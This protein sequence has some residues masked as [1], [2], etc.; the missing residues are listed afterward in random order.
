MEELNQ[1]RQSEN[2]CGLAE[3]ARDRL[4]FEP[5]APILLRALAQ[6]LERLQRK[7]AE[8]ERALERL[9]ELKDR[10]VETAQRLSQYFMEMGNEK[11]AVRHLEIALEAATAERQYDKIEELWLDMV[12]L[13][14]Q[15]LNFF[16]RVADH[17]NGIKQRQ[18]ASVLLQ[19][20]LPSTEERKDWPNRFRLLRRI[21]EY[22]P[23]DPSLREPLVE[24]LRQLH[25]E[26]SSMERVL[27]Y[28]GIRGNRPLPEALVEVE[29]FMN[30]LPGCYVRH[31]DWGIGLVKDLNMLDRRVVINF[32][33][34]RDHAMDVE[35]AQTVIEPLSA[36][37]FRV[38]RVINPSGLTAL[39]RENP[40]GLIKLLLKSYGGSLT[41]KEIKEHLV[42]A[43]INVREWTSWWSETSSALRREKFIAVSA[44]ALKKY[45]LREQEVSDEEELLLRFD[46]TKAPHDKVDQIYTYLR[47]TKKG[48]LHEYVVQHFSRKIQAMAPSRRSRAERVELWFTNEDL[49]AYAPGIESVDRVILD[50]ALR[51]VTRLSAIM[52][53][54]RFKSHQALFAR[55][56]KQAH[57]AEW[58]GLFQALLLEPDVLVRDELARDLEQEGCQ[59][60]ILE[61]V[62]QALANFRTFPHTF[63]WLGGR[64]LTGEGTNW[65][66]GKI[67]PAVVI[68]R[69]L[70]LVD[71][72]TSQ[73]KRRDK[74][75]AAR[76]RKVAGD[77]RELIRRN[78]YNLFKLHIQNADETVAQSIYR[79]ALTNEGIDQRTAA[80]LTTIVRARYPN[81]FTAAATEGPALPEGLLCLKATYDRKRALLRRLIEV[82]LPEVVRE[83]ETA[84]K[85]GDLR[86][87]A[88]YHAAKDKQKLLAAQAAELKE[89][90]HTAKPVELGEVDTGRIGFG[91]RFRVSPSSADK[92]EE[93][94]MLGPWESD[95][96][97]NIL[98]YQAPF[99][100]TFYG[101]QM[102]E[103]VDVELPM[104]TG[105]YEILS[106]EPVPP[107]FLDEIAGHE[108]PAGLEDLAA[109]PP[110][111]EIH[112]DA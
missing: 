57:P 110:E 58:P 56:I 18:R 8:Y 55:E 74:D 100:Q 29:L 22:T 61:V 26:S 109:A 70:L 101:R 94:I 41:A 83:I 52:Q 90:L 68:E 93:Y 105:R 62:E 97:R 20:L 38:Q 42:P 35:L 47:T 36:D 67:S 40:V 25:P 87:N 86:E 102:G 78:H 64:I 76:L 88:E 79:R 23:K 54:L 106:V 5:D 63:I 75:E 49:K 28:T 11:E 1:L 31:P 89:S 17:L 71:Y 73:A 82:E 92:V 34:K 66:E 59:A 50:E 32:Q 14:P 69:L 45:V 65:C 13:E 24:T 99:A 37:D 4:Q 98:S 6:A 43:V 96:S 111:S 51:D 33:K 91:A 30:F 80:D 10:V 77:A 12:E 85:H 46:E 53:H 3:K 2:W 107:G 9:L 60:C 19:M 108:P 39:L 84:R 81:L 21:L 48:D 95:P 104:H 7:D 27:D 44:G 103:I 15:N 112:H 16:F 72:L